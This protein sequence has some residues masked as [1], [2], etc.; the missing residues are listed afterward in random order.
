MN[1]RRT[2]QRILI[3]LVGISLLFAGGVNS[4]AAE[5]L[6]LAM[7][8][9]LKN[10]EASG[11]VI[12][13]QK[14]NNMK[15]VYAGEVVWNNNGQTPR[16]LS[17]E[18][19][20][21]QEKSNRYYQVLYLEDIAGGNIKVEVGTD[22]REVWRIIWQYNKSPQAAVIT[23][24]DRANTLVD[25][26]FPFDL[27]HPVYKSYGTVAVKDIDGRACY[28]ISMVPFEG[29]PRTLWFDKETFSLA[30]VQSSNGNSLSMN[31][32]MIKFSDYKKINGVMVAHKM[33]IYELGFGTTKYPARTTLTA[34][35]I[36]MNIAMPKDRFALPPMI[37]KL[38]KEEK[39][40]LSS[41]E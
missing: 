35:S 30:A 15:I 25:F 6:P 33:E 32:Q 4:F 18:S 38:V 9:L 28:E 22:G 29:D 31:P 19:T 5:E 8:I 16:P 24:E 41:A 26:H 39:G 3:A 11:G 23:G 12:A 27:H 20:V 36:E 17:I 34:K 21:Y 40:G 7:T 13:Y 1:R 2:V 37:K 10:I 14:I